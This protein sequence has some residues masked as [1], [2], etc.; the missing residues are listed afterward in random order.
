M[1]GAR[2]TIRRIGLLL[3]ATLAIIGLPLPLAAQDQPTLFEAEP[4]T[5]EQGQPAE[6][7]EGKAWYFVST[8]RPSFDVDDALTAF[9]A[10]AFTA[11]FNP[12][13]ASVMQK[14]DLWIALPIRAASENSRPIRRSVG[15]GGI[16]YTVPDIYLAKG[17]GGAIKIL[18]GPAT[19]DNE[20]LHQKLTYLHS[21]SFELAPGQSELLMINLAL[22]DRPSIGLFREGELGRNQIIGTLLKAGVI[23]T[24][25]AVGICLIVLGILA[26]RPNTIIVAIGFSLIAIQSDVSLF[27][28]ILAS[29]FEQARLIWRSSISLISLTLA[30]MIIAA[31]WDAITARTNK[32]A[33]ALLLLA[34]LGIVG[35]AFLLH[36]DSLLVGM[37]YV[38]VLGLVAVVAFRIE[39][40]KGLRRIAVLSIAACSIAIVL[41]EPALMGTVV[42]ELFSNF[43]RDMM[44]LAVSATLLVIVIVD[45]QRNLLERDR[46]SQERIAALQAQ[47]EAD[48]RLLQTEREYARAR[49]TAVR[50]K[51][52][53][54]SASHDIRQ[55]LVG[56]RASIREEA[57]NLSPDLQER[58]GEAIDYLEELTHEYSDQDNR[59]MPLKTE[60][61]ELYSLDLI[62]E[63]VEEMFA[64]E[65]AASG[66]TL[67]TQR[68]PCETRIPALALIRSV[69][70]LIANA[71]RHAEASEVHLAVRHEDGCLIEVRD[72]GR[73]MDEA[74]LQKVQQRG[75]K[76]QS[77]KGD[78][79]GLAII[80]DLARRH[81]FGF[82]L[83]SSVG[84][85]TIAT[86]T[87]P[88]S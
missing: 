49:E 87:L 84:E 18:G 81:G 25:L 45:I 44:R 80:H 50:R 75:A 9:N 20:L 36:K 59:V 8:G 65:A 24:F 41:V 10:G 62:V 53:L 46:L 27:T 38:L 21:A 15:L 47:S 61:R 34:P 39:T 1:M 11:N 68:A 76:D 6:Q 51:Q 30:Y 7:V 58:L 82:A 73:G 57:D 83:Q 32:L 17:E 2:T 13:R 69:S 56:L 28:T 67:T 70:N 54:A 42:P 5:L 43:V 85:G 19:A 3:V 77:S 86:I 26:R 12:Q 55:P 79:L 78:G 22:D 52:Q 40:A 66:I 60:E 64:A 4:V 33:R 29:S 37:F 16:F 71:L 14:R 23:I 48:Q 31:F 72:N 63:T 35:A 88:K 74:S